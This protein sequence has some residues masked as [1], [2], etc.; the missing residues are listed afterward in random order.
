MSEEE[1][2]EKRKDLGIA[3]NDFFLVSVGE[4]NENKN[5]VV[6][7]KICLLYTSPSPRDCS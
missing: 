2:K 6:V 1:K 3:E 4:L 5:H 7:L